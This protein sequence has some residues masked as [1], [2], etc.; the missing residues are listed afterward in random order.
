MA[1]PDVSLSIQDGTLG[2]LAPSGSNIALK[3]GV[4]SAGTANVIQSFSDKKSLSAAMG[5]GPLVDAAA[6]CLD[7][8]GGPVYVAR[9]TATT[10]GS[11][12]S[13]THV[14]TGTAVLTP[15]GSPL[16]QYDVQALITRGAANLAALTAAFKYT[17]DGGD[18]FSPEIAVPVGGVYAIPGTG[19]TITWADGTFVANDTYTFSTV[20][21]SYALS[22]LQTALTAILADT[23]QWG[24]V[25]VVG[26]AASVAA[27][28][29]M[30]AGLD[31]TMQSAET[32]FRY[33][34]AVIE[35][36]DDTDANIIAAFA[37]TASRRVMCC[38]GYAEIMSPISGLI[39]KRSS[40]WIASARI[41]QVPI[42]EDLGRVRTGPVTGVVKLYRD[43]QAT[44][45]LDA[46]RFTTLRTIIGQPGFW[47]TSGRMIA[48]AG[49]DF[50]YVQ[51]R[52]VMD[53]ACAEARNGFMRYL[54]DSVRLD[55]ATGFILEK[56]ARAIESDVQ[57]QLEVG[58]VNP[59]HASGADVRVQRDHNIIS[60]ATMPV[61]VTVTPLGYAKNI[62]VTIGFI[63]PSLKSKAA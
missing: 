42:H 21:P 2:L 4:C 18:S 38:A 19:L 40:A 37:S 33:T 3:V 20:A 52:R 14:G 61:T 29:A 53:E 13:V 47:L 12:G 32:A 9:I 28:A 46:A 23:R 35:V 1:L 5:T 22:D 62:T 27:A 49:S 58:L 48:P 25:H 45:G 8:A 60:D 54:N 36:P 55:N 26:A 50:T 44:P 63:N 16:D 6:L 24:H 39:R 59:G 43:E 51:N 15:S 57:G 7:T 41:A 56:E 10:S 31:T 11:S 34:F 17:L 30:A